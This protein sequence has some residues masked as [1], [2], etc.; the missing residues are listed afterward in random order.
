[1]DQDLTDDLACSNF[2]RCDASCHH[3][4]SPAV[5]NSLLRHWLFKSHDKSNLDIAS[6]STPPPPLPGSLSVNAGLI[7]NELM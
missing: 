4:E 2:E 1:M 7:F 5:K 3:Q 6:V